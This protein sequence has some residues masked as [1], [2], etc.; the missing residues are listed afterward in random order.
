MYLKLRNIGKITE[1]DIEL[2]GMTV[3][4]GENNTGKSTVSKAL[5]SAFNSLY[6]YEDEIYKARYQTVSR[7]ISRY[8]SSRYN[9]IEQNFQFNDLFNENLKEYI[10][11]II[12]NPKEEDF[13]KHFQN[14]HEL[15]ISVMTEFG[16]SE[17]GESDENSDNVKELK[18]SI[19]DAL[20]IS[21]Q[22]IHNRLT[23]NIFRGEFDDQVNNLYIDGEAS[24]ELIIKN[25]TTIFNIE[26]NTVKYIGNPKMLKTQAVYLDD[27]FVLD[28]KTN[29]W[30]MSRRNDHRSMLKRR[31]L[32]ESK[33]DTIEQIVVDKKIDKIFEK[34]NSV[35]SGDLISDGRRNVSYRP[36]EREESIRMS[37]ISSGLKTFIIIKELLQNGTLEKNGTL[38]L[39]EPEIHLHP[40]WQILLA[41]L[42]VLIQKE[43]GMH[44]LLT[45]HSPYFLYAV[46]VFTAR[47]DL[48]EQCNYYIAENIMN[49]VVF[50]NVSESIDEIYKKL[51]DPFQKLENLSYE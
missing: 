28:D 49:D 26:K 10:N 23:T 41:E 8:I 32:E 30:I 20:K 35:V 7:A 37:N 36:K 39:D 43:F 1:A 6:K 11:L 51:S 19:T 48:K 45:T 38:I 21:N 40:E 27:P 17:T 46:E 12:L 9:L 44:I 34:L 18:L 15:I 14:I 33:S 50:R 42:I 4:A 2:T 22:D 31:L 47:Y 29:F 16:L 5:F 24:I 3:I 25:G 13:D